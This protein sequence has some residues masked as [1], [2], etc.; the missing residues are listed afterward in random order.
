MRV[1]R[2]GAYHA[3]MDVA[4]IRAHHQDVKESAMTY[5]LSIDE[6]NEKARELAR[7]VSLLH[8]ERIAAK[9]DQQSHT[10]IIKSLYEQITSLVSIIQSGEESRDTQLELELN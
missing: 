8:E 7:L 5:R 2:G 6:I 10:L 9:R 1:I 4:K 3:V